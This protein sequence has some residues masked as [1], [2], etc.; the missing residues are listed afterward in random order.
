MNDIGVQSLPH[1]V[2][3]SNSDAKVLYLLYQLYTTMTTIT[4]LC[5]SSQSYSQEEND[6]LVP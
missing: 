1:M 2:N 4:R 5:C 3:K 6:F